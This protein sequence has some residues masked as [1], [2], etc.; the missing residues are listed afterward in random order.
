MAHRGY[1]MAYFFGLWRICK[2]QAQKLRD[3]LLQVA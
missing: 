1:M 2:S 3:T